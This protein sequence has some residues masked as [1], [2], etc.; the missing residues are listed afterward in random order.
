MTT[1]E[2]ISFCRLLD[3]DCRPPYLV[4]TERMGH[5]VREAEKEAAERALY[6]KIDK[7]QWINVKADQPSYEL[8][9][10]IIFI[11]RVK[12]QTGTQPIFKTT[13]CE[14]DFAQGNWESKTGTP[15]HYIQDK[16]TIRLYPTPLVDDILMLTG[17]RRPMFDM[18][19]PE[20]RHEDLAQWVLYRYFSVRDADTYNPVKAAEY[21]NEF[22]NL[23]GHKRDAFF[24]RTWRDYAQHPA[25]KV[26][27]FN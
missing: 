17:S 6:L 26:S 1:D 12:L 11:D 22:S 2:L 10:E 20:E 27:P 14:L 4:S 15:R 18:E 23:F 8:S 13:E 16:N 24:E 21:L 19:T 9:P 7:E 3:D 25:F 5:F